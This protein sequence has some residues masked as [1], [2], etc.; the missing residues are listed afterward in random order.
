MPLSY[1]SSS[2]PCRLHV[3][4]NCKV[5]PCLQPALGMAM[6][7]GMWVVGLVHIF[8]HGFMDLYIRNTV[9]LEQILH[10]TR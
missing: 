2:L 5:I 6:D 1:S 9:G 10:F 3:G 4:P 8:A 7:R